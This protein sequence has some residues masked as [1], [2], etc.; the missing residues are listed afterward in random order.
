MELVLGQDQVHI[1]RVWLDQSMAVVER[2]AQHLSPDERTR[3]ER[4]YFERDRIRFIVARGQLRTILGGYLGIEPSRVEFSYGSHG[5]PSLA[6]GFAETKLQFN[7]SHSQGLALYGVTCDRILGIDLEQIRPVPQS[8]QIARRFFSPQ[9]ADVLL[10][11][12]S[13]LKDEA[14]L[15]YWTCKEAYLKASGEG[16]AQPMNEVEVSLI[17]GEPARLDRIAG[18]PEKAAFWSL[19]TLK[20]AP[21]YL[22]AIVVE[23]DNWHP[24]YW[25]CTFILS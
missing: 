22:A 21:D 9:E 7:L 2:L 18:S 3:A 25:E 5:K 24:Q 13:Y 10:A 15:R 8:E 23:G 1:W 17:S 14:F 20:P 12:P 4:F 16:L 11:L 19:Q 6:Q